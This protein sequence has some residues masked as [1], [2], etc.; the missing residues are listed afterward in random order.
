RPPSQMVRVHVQRDAKH[1]NHEANMAFYRSLGF[2]VV[3]CRPPKVDRVFSRATSSHAPRAPRKPFL[4]WPL[5]SNGRLR[6]MMNEDKENWKYA[7]KPACVVRVYCNTKGNRQI[8]KWP[9]YQSVELIQVFGDECVLALTDAQYNRAIKAGAIDAYEYI[10]TKVVQYME[11]STAYT[12]EAI[13]SSIKD[14]SS[15]Q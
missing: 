9:D 12:D 1:V 5:L 8:F 14:T 4:G 15:I 2:I 10:S 3:D 7:K 13:Q 6:H 11:T